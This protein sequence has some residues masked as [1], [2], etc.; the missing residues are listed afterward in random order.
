MEE[1]NHFWRGVLLGAL[2]TAGLGLVV[3]LG[4]GLLMVRKVAASWQSAA[5]SGTGA[6]T[7]DSA[8]V[9]AAGLN[10]DR[11]DQKIEYIQQIIDNYYLFEEDPEKVE[12]MI[13]TGML[14]GLEDPYSVYYNKE[15]YQSMRESLSG[16]YCGIGAMVSQNRT[17]G[18]ITVTRVFEGAPAAEAGM[19]AGDILYKV[20]DL[21]ATGQDLDLLVSNHIR[22]EENTPV[23]ITVLRGEELEEILLDITRRKVEIPTVAYQM[24]ED[25]IGYIELT[26]FEAASSDQ[27]IEACEDLEK[28]GMEA[29]VID[30]RDN[31]GGVL[32]TAVELMAYILP[33][34]QYEGR[35]VTTADKNGEGDQ[36]VSSGGKVSYHSD[37]GYTDK[38]YPFPDGHELEVPYAI[39]VNGNSASASEVLTGAV[40]DYGSGIVIGTQTF[41]KGIVQNLIPLGDGTAIKLTT[42]HYYTPSGYDLHGV[43]L[44]PD[45]ILE[46]DPETAGDLTKDNQLQAAIAALKKA[47]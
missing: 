37:F 46:L 18:L 24:L 32:D 19:K 11:I 40:L 13:Y 16:E 31:P 28:Q 26:Q 25:Q 41:G 1:K 47:Q 17:T 6:G 12:D 44:T 36:Y 7:A 8:E 29:L 42:Q 14:A 34:D 15:D 23:Q 35:L 22:G 38:N 3:T 30:L 20:G 9:P 33:D 21:E 43:G 27:F 4:A 5:V 45:I 10:R 2:V 39:L